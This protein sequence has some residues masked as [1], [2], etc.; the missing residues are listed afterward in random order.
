MTDELMDLDGQITWQDRGMQFGK[1]SQ[2]P[3]V[4]EP[5]KGQTSK[6]S[7]RSSSASQT[8]ML[9]MCLCLKTESG[10]SQ[11]ISTM[12]WD[13]GVLPGLL[14]MHSITDLHKDENGLLWCAI[15]TDYLP[16]KL[17]LTLNTGE[18]PRES[19]QAKLSDILQDDADLKYNLSPKACFGILRRAEK[20]GK[21][22]P[23]ILRE[24]LESQADDFLPSGD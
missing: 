15:S 1:M 6:E 9:P 13:D 5:R 10:A 22:L 3:L 23:E 20:R 2:V 19:N 4:Q 24:A 11:D 7:S 21:E 16:E 12:K 14:T 18:R 8:R 17:Y